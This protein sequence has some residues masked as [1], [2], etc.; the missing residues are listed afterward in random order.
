M[1]ELASG[2]AQAF[3]GT[4]LSGETIVLR[5]A[6]AAMLGAVL[7][8]EREW[9]AKPAGLRTHMV[10]ALAAATFAI[11]TLEMIALYSGGAD[12]VRADP[13]RLIEAVTSGVAFLA[14]G[15]ILHARG[16]VEG[17]TTGAGMWLAGAVGVAAGL[18]YA[19]IAAL[20]AFLGLFIVIAL[21][22]VSHNVPLRKSG[23]EKRSDEKNA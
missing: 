15:V 8:F 18:G 21:R 6:L 5:L 9:R 10:T 2:F 20:A 7:G 23:S 17:L 4:E 22:S 14:A 19:L 13:T 16:H 12:N 3:Q 1:E 11:L